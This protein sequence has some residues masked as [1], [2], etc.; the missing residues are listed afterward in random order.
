MRTQIIAAEQSIGKRFRPMTGISGIRGQGEFR[1]FPKSI[2]PA[3]TQATYLG[4][5]T[6]SAV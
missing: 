2:V 6:V 1:S 3:E 5:L 4:L